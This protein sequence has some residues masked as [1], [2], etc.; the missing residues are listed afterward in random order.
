LDVFDDWARGREAAATVERRALLRCLEAA[1]IADL[2]CATV[3]APDGVLAFALL[4]P[5]PDGWAVCPFAKM[6]PSCPDV[7][8]L[9]WRAL[10]ELSEA[11][12]FR[13]VNYEQDLGLPGLRQNKMSLRPARLLEKVRLQF[14][15]AE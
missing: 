5:Q 2:C 10:L 6:R 8:R 4:A 12:G 7:G 11:R 9:L 15:A 3:V 1:A 14:G 13:W